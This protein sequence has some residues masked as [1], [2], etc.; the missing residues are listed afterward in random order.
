MFPELIFIVL[1]VVVLVAC[2][3]GPL[4]K[5]ANESPLDPHRQI[6]IR[7]LATDQSRITHFSCDKALIDQ[8]TYYDEKSYDQAIL[9]AAELLQHPCSAEALQN[10]YETLGDVF[11][12]TERPVDA[13]LFYSESARLAEK[14]H[15]KVLM[16]KSVAAAVTLP[17]QR[18]R[19]ISRDIETAA[20]R[21]DLF[22]E[23]AD[24]LTNLEK[25]KDALEILKSYQQEFPSDQRIYQ[26]ERAIEALQSKTAF[27]RNRIGVLLPLSGRF[28][29]IGR[30]VLKAIEI[31]VD[32]HNHEVRGQRLQIIV[33][34]TGADPQRAIAA[35]NSLNQKRV[36]GII[37]PLVTARDAAIQAN[38]LGIP[39]IVMTQKEDVPKI[40][41]YIFRNFIT[42]EIQAETLIPYLTA[43]N[44]QRRFAVLYPD[45]SYGRSFKDAFVSKIALFDGELNIVESYLPGQTDFS[46]QIQRFIQGYHKVGKNGEITFLDTDA[47]R[48][49]HGNYRALVDFDVLFIPD[50]SEV[51]AM[52][53]PQLKYH[54]IEDITLV[55]TNLWSSEKLI[56]LAGP[57]VQGA[58]YPIDL[59]IAADSVLYQAFIYAY[60]LTDDEPPGIIEAIG[61]DTAQIMLQALSQPETTSRKDLV[62]NLLAI[63][64]FD[65]VTGISSFR[66]SGE[67]VINLQLCKIVNNKSFII[68]N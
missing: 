18:F 38:R 53:A 40:G 34:D 65:G 8:Q 54:D 45:E 24:A 13:I 58:I 12:A 59:G 33:K 37:G 32:R 35:V 26:A 47:P 43:N 9:A 7:S 29:L 28:E 60:S 55:G 39:M 4:P 19:T 14:D 51:V 5:R 3:A 46:Q 50:S 49:K 57:Y 48:E 63:K 2:H 21:K 64:R 67:P 62:N 68:H 15:Q 6:K 36:A 61:F 56:E 66:P 52:I 11:H 17:P 10:T 30:R 16:E 20:W 22:L 25:H 42:P 44:A 31:A 27:N 23:V 1:I 41:K